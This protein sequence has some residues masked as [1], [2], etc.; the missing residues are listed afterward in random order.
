MV[1]DHDFGVS[2][3]LLP[4]QRILRHTPTERLAELRL[5]SHGSVGKPSL[6][7][8]LRGTCHAPNS[9]TRQGNE[10]QGFAGQKGGAP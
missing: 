3:V 10:D 1:Y 8:S 6:G 2:H 4:D 5:P 9:V 7:P